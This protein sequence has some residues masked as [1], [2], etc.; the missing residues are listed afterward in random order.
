LPLTVAYG[1][2][3]PPASPREALHR[4]ARQ[5]G[6]VTAGDSDR[7]APLA[8]TFQPAQRTLLASVMR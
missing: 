2:P 3:L 4:M 8:A 5:A 7:R 6:A 1:L